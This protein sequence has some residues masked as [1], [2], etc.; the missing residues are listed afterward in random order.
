MTNR[1]QFIQKLSILLKEKN[2]R[3][4]M[5]LVGQEAVE[6]FK[7]AQTQPHTDITDFK[8]ISDLTRHVLD[9]VHNPKNE[10]EIVNH[11]TLMSE[12]IVD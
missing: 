5:V 11:I 9:Y 12:L 4:K 8:L 7:K 2:D 3:I 1:Q 10:K 6:V